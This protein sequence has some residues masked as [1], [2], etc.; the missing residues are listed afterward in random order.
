M[1]CV[2]IESPRGG[3]SYEYTHYTFILKKTEKMTISRFL[4][5]PIISPHWPELPLSRT[6]FYSP[7]GVRANIVRLC[8]RT[9]VRL[10]ILEN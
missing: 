2:L 5:W 6:N 9:T 4:A 3:D 1:L 10:F 7:K 8:I